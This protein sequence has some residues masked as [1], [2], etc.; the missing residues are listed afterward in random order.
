M[1]GPSTDLW[2]TVLAAGYMTNNVKLIGVEVC[3]RN[4]RNILYKCDKNFAERR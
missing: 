1:S 2:V 3:Y 4:F